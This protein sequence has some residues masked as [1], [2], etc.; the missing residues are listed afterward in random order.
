M[1]LRHG[2]A[3]GSWQGRPGHLQTR[4]CPSLAIECIHEASIN[5]AGDAVKAP[6]LLAMLLSPCYLAKGVIQEMLQ[7]QDCGEMS[8]QPSLEVSLP[9]IL[10]CPSVTPSHVC[11]CTGMTLPAWPSFPAPAVLRRAR[12][13][14]AAAAH[15]Q[16]RSLAQSCS[17]ITMSAAPRRRFCGCSRPRRPFWIPWAQLPGSPQTAQP[18]RSATGPWLSFGLCLKSCFG[19]GMWGLA[20]C[21][22]GETP[23][24]AR[25]QP[26][27]TPQ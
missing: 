19:I 10:V 7:E 6:S 23:G 12:K 27:C 17:G 25:A 24:A 9:G 22:A 21:E 1:Q 11:R 15:N 16:S 13:T 4:V 5:V 14:A 18:L 8:A 3:L 26:G 20:C 2:S